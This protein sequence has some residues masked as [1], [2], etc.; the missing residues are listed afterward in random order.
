MNSLWQ[1]IRYGVRMLVK[2]RGVALLAIL[3]LGL[4]VGANTATFSVSNTFLRKPVSFPEVE[5]LV[6]VVNRA[7]GQVQDWTSASPADFLDWKEQA[8]SFDSLTA[9]SWNDINLTGAG[10][11]VKLQ[12]FRVTPNFFDVLSVHA[13]SYTHLTLPTICSV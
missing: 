3:A 7:P 5:R 9:Y 4:G 8:H 13:V 12:G 1:D 11:P 10:E 2:S 6:M